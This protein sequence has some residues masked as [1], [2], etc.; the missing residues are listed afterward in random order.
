MTDL[1]LFFCCCDRGNLRSPHPPCHPDGAQ[2]RGICI[3]TSLV[4]PLFPTNAVIPTERS[5]EGSAVAFR[6]PIRFVPTQRAVIPTAR[7]DEGPAVA[8]RWHGRF[9]PNQCAV[10]PTERS[11]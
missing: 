8:L 11:D 1:R 6:R 10:I 7:S 9:V 3:C 5:D 4:H 2:R